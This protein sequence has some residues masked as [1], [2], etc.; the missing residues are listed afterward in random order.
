MVLCRT[1]AC[2]YVS[3]LWRLVSSEGIFFNHK[4]H[5]SLLG[6]LFTK[7]CF[8]VVGAV[9]CSILPRALLYVF[10][11]AALAGFLGGLFGR[12]TLFG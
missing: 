1:F 9:F 4:S 3:Q 5:F 12:F 2:V 10:L 7:H 6:C 11:F 8:L